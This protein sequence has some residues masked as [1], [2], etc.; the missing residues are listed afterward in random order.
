MMMMVLVV[1]PVTHL[2]LL[3]VYLFGGLCFRSLRVHFGLIGF[4]LSGLG[5]SLR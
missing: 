1:G 4:L 5:G 3:F 2:G